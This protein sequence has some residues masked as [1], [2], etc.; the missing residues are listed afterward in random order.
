MVPAL[1]STEWLITHMTDNSKRVEIFCYHS[2][3]DSKTWTNT[4]DH[5]GGRGIVTSRITDA[6]LIVN[7]FSA[8]M[9]LI[10]EMELNVSALSQNVYFS[11]HVNN[12]MLECLVGSIN[13]SQRL[14]FPQPKVP[15]RF[16]VKQD[17]DLPGLYLR[18]EPSV[19]NPWYVSRMMV[20][21]VS[22]MVRQSNLHHRDTTKCSLMLVATSH[23]SSKLFLRIARANV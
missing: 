3:R 22:L 18:Q 13:F 6:E 21:S 16:I 11:C 5:L 1:I 9:A 4:Q 2:C 14:S 23:M 12:S 8:K 19:E 10:A 17:L 20:F 15:S 7:T